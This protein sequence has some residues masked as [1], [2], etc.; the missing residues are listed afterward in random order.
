M[1]NK[2]YEIK[3]KNK[4]PEVVIKKEKCEPLTKQGITI[5]ADLRCAE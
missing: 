3:F 2:L 5:V 4:F 1:T